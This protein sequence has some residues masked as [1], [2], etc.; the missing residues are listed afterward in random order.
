MRLLRLAADQGHS[1]AQ[2]Y[3]GLSY[4]FGEGVEQN[5]GEAV[6]WY[7]VAANQGHADSQIALGF[8]QKNREGVLSTRLDRSFAVA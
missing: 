4:G 1:G 6:R 7:R 8:F 3:F 2:Y 5:Y